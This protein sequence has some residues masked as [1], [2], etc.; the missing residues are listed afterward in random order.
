MTTPAVEAEADLGSVF[1]QRRRE[2]LV[3]CYRMTGSFADAEDLTQETFL[4]AWRSRDGFRHGSSLRTWLY[5]IATNAC[6]DF[7]ALHERRAAPTD[8]LT[9]LLEGEGRIGPFP[10][11]R[12]TS[13]PS[14]P[15]PAVVV[16]ARETTELMLVAA[17]LRLP[18]RQRI[19]LIAREFLGLSSTE[20]AA[21]LGVS[22]PSANSLVQRARAEVRRCHGTSERGLP[23]APVDDGLVRRYVRAHQDGD[24]DAITAM[25]AADVRVSMP[26]EEPAIGRAAAAAFFT[27]AV[28]PS[29]PGEW[30]LVTARAN[31]RPATVNYLRRPGDRLFRALSVDVLTFRGGQLEAIHCFTDHRA[32][33]AFGLPI[34]TDR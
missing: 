18:P 21:L 24:V 30:R 28:G 13:A 22:V 14:G 34:E 11:W 12:L 32:V 19:A 7:L 6:L 23:D 29:R 16:E 2:L 15:D 9:E 26:P 17:L 10:D 31:G 20:T 3:L 25:L 8:S 5:R 1:E 33:A 27:R 4:R